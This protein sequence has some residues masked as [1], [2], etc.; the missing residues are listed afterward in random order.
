MKILG[1]I[2]VESIPGC[3]QMN[4]VIP[5]QIINSLH[6]FRLEGILLWAV[7]WFG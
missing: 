7:P 5:Q 4:N 3:N 6:A 2:A 1:L